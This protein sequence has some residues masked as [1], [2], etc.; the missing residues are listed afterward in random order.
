MSEA[1]AEAE[2]V[3]TWLGLAWDPEY[4]VKRRDE[5]NREFKLNAIVSKEDANLTTVSI[6]DAK[7]LYDNLVREQW[8]GTEK[9]AALEICVIRDSLEALNGRARWVPH[10][11]NPVDCMTKL[12]G[13]AARM[14]QLMRTASYKLVVEKEELVRRKEYR[15]ETGRRNPRPS[16]A[17][18]IRGNYASFSQSPQNVSST[19]LF[20]CASNPGTSQPSSRLSGQGGPVQDIWSGISNERRVV[21]KMSRR[22]TL[23]RDS[24]EEGPL[25]GDLQAIR[26]YSRRVAEATMADNLRAQ[27]DQL[28]QTLLLM[29]EAGVAELDFSMNLRP[30]QKVKLEKYKEQQCLVASLE[31]DLAK[32]RESM[33]RDRIHQGSKRQPRSQSSQSTQG[34]PERDSLSGTSRTGATVADGCETGGPERDSLPGT[35]EQPTAGSSSG[36]EEDIGDESLTKG[37]FRSVPDEAFWLFVGIE[38]SAIQRARRTQEEKGTFHP[39]P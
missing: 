37:E 30:G 18:E 22:F 16:R 3:A 7:S 23:P 13:N 17:N 21:A 24:R 10:E 26:D 4:D 34:G 29:E 33:V 25:P 14:L 11:E 2:W 39:A 38:V 6:T 19:C 20:M 5:I 35:S 32:V 36:Q 27:I 12:H 31:D 1:L 28:R 15:E 9:R 8:A